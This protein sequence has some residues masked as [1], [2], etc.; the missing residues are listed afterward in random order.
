MENKFC[1]KCGNKIEEEQ[2]F[3]PK[4][5]NKVS[6]TKQKSIEINKC[7]KQNGKAGNIVRYIFGGLF[8]LG[9]LINLVNGNWYGIIELLFS[10]SL[11]PF[12]YNNFLYKFIKKSKILK[13]MQIVIPIALLVIFIMVTPPTTDE[14]NN[15]IPSNNGS[16]ES[17]K[18]EEKKEL[19]EAEKMI[20]KITSLMDENL[21]FDTGDYIKGD[22]PAGEYAFVKFSGSGEYYCEKDGSGNIIDNENF[23]S[24]GYV[25]VHAAGNLT[26]RGVLVS[27]NAFEK[28]EVTGA[29]QL[30]EI[31]NNQTD[32]NE[33]GYYKIGVDIPAGQYV[34][35]SYGSGYWAVMSAP[36]GASD[37][38]D[39]DNFNGRASVS[40]KNGQYLKVSSAKITQ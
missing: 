24:F 25:K 5:G 8:T 11:M 6:G 32:Y 14:D 28:L 9:S 20:I 2:V 21:A 30:Y 36:V 13:I 33:G 34:I 22:I 17:T 4:C 10:V 16:S 31:L 35:E 29:K 38:V 15:Y 19:T 1:S 12:V 40:V 7:I 3:C 27:V 23:D 39:N 37:I 18:K 26:T